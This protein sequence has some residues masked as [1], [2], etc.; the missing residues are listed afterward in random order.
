MIS[1]SWAELLAR[2]HLGI[3]PSQLCPPGQHPLYPAVE[4]GYSP[5]TPMEPGGMG[6]WHLHWLSVLMLHLGLSAIY[7]RYTSMARTK[8]PHLAPGPDSCDSWQSSSS[9]THCHPAHSASSVLPLLHTA[10]GT[11]TSFCLLQ[12]SSGD[13]GKPHE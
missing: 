12:N 8:K 6:R 3:D 4:E 10:L 2:K 11:S 7:L 13:H 1:L 9:G 5:D